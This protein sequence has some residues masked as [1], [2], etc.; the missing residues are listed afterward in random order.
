MQ[1]DLIGIGALNFDYIHRYIPRIGM[2]VIRLQESGEE[3]LNIKPEELERLINTYS[4]HD[5]NYHPRFGGSAYLTVKTVGS[6]NLSFKTGFVGIIGKPVQLEI[7][8]GIKEDFLK[9]EFSH[10]ASHE[11]LFEVSEPPG[12]ALVLT[13]RGK[14]QWIGISPGA[15]NLLWDKIKHKE[16]AAGEKLE[17]YLA[18]SKWVHITSLSDDQQFEKIIGKVKIAKK[19]NTYLRVS[20]D[21]GYQYTKKLSEWL[22]KILPVADF[23][24]L[25]QNELDN[26]KGGSQ[27]SMRSRLNR[28]KS[29]S[30]NNTQVIIVKGK[31]RHQLIQ[32]GLPE[33]RKRTYWHPKLPAKRIED[34]TGAGDVLAGG[35]I[36]GILTPRLLAHQPAP[37][38]LGAELAVAKLCS[39]DFPLT[40]FADVTSRFLNRG[41]Q[42]E[43]HN[44]RQRIKVFFSSVR[45]FLI[46]F[47]ISFL[48]G[49]AA[50]VFIDRLLR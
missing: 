24:F 33:I 14:R 29:L 43:E 49:T 15:N 34:D 40:T 13:R 7:N 4:T 3:E 41:M 10:L 18:T 35:I 38:K 31:K 17:E 28:L 5:E 45:G 23:I 30:G 20:I 6:V 8:G 9:D 39:P 42:I 47:L 27:F 12:R 2:G 19:M 32:F 46:A 11:W 1:L 22:A 16:G 44:I 36:A 26:L 25:N 48:A 21:P 37:I 50:G